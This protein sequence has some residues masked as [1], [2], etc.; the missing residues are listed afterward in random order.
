MFLVIIMLFLLDIWGPKLGKFLLKQFRSFSRLYLRHGIR[1]IHIVSSCFVRTFQCWQMMLTLSCL[2]LVMILYYIINNI[3]PC[4]SQ[5]NSGENCSGQGPICET[6]KSPSDYND[7]IE[8]FNNHLIS[9]DLERLHNL[10]LISII[11]YNISS[12][13]RTEFY[14]Y[15][16]YQYNIINVACQL[17]AVCS[18]FPRLLL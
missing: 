14:L 9:K 4:S 2:L 17:R 15:F 12:L 11:Y 7:A 13:G 18:K 5:P 6:N 3:I 8:K 16:K 10:N 1:S